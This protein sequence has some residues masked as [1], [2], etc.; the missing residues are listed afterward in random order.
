MNRG[1][2]LNGAKDR[3]IISDHQ[4]LKLRH[5][6][7]DTPDGLVALV[8]YPQKKHDEYVT[9][10]IMYLGNQPLFAQHAPQIAAAVLLCR[11]FLCDPLE[12]TSKRVIDAIGSAKHARCAS[13][14]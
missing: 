11:S 13:T 10:E 2:E 6:A 8:V 7:V 14:R 9:H 12:T 4:G 5:L 3:K 1:V